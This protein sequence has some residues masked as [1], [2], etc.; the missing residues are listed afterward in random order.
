MTGFITL[1]HSGVAAAP[2]V[3]TTASAVTEVTGFI[4]GTY[5]SIGEVGSDNVTQV[6]P[7]SS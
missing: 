2:A 6:G 7:C 1:N 5:F 4:G 3:A